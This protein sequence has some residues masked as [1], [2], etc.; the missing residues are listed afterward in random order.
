M[1]M[2]RARR[3]RRDLAVLLLL[4]LGAVGWP[5]PSSAAPPAGWV[6]V[7]PA[8]LATMRGGAVLP[9]GLVVSFGFHREVRVDGVLVAAMHVDI[10]DVAR[11]GQAEAEALARLAAGQVVQLGAGGVAAVA[12]DGGL[13]VQNSLSG[14]QLA[15]DTRIDAGVASLAD[16][17]MARLADGLMQ[18]GITGATP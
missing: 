18:A 10:P 14:I 15:V 1:A 17:H 9:S 12:P 8:H 13:V 11:M 16:W 6:P 2:H 5:G 7:P 4:A 3:L